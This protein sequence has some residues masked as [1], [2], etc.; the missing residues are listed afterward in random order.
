MRRTFSLVLLLLAPALADGPK[1]PD[2]V[3]FDDDL[4]YGKGG[5]VDLT[6]DLAR[7]KEAK[8]PCRCILII[9]G[10]GWAAGQKEV[11]DD[12]TWE[13]ARRGWVAASVGYRLAPKHPFPAQV[14][15]VKCAV[16][17]LRAHA[18]EYGIDPKKIGAMGFSAGAHLSMMLG[19]MGKDDGLEGE[20][21]WADQSSQVEAVVSFFGPAD[22]L[23]EDL[24]D[25]SKEILRNWIGGT[26]AE[27]EDAYRKA[28][29][30]TYV[31][32]GD[33]PMLLLQGTKDPLVPH[34]Q[35]YVMVE[36]LTQAGVSG[37]VEL[38]IGQGHGWPDPAEIKR[39][40]EVTYAFLEER[41]R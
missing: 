20:G 25:Q 1:P 18:E 22:T 14:E 36:A 15:D 24:P 35:A 4:V 21:G 32:P 28:S 17:F 38:L 6:L 31:S 29:P 10:G 7:P 12:M 16:R 3:R 30:L 27:M 37:R 13:F 41:L 5:D 2:D 9:H 23:A 34:T 19:V 8:G 39:S 26:A 11:H 40:L 33:A